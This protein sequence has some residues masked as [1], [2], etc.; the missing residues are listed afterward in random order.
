MSG[1]N[2]EVSV[3]VPAYNEAKNVTLLHRQLIQ[4]LT[5]VVSF[6]IIFVDDGSTDNTFAELK[7][8][9][10]I[11]IIRL[12][13]N[14]G[15]TAAFAAGIAVAQGEWVVTIDGDLENDPRDILRLLAKTKDG[16]DLVS[17][18]RQDRWRGQFFARQLP[19]WLANKLISRATAVYLHDHG[20]SLKIYRRVYLEN[21]HIHGD[22]HRMLAAY[23]VRNCGARIA[24]LPVTF[25]PRIYGQSKYGLSRTFKVILDIITFRF[26]Q[27]YGRQPMHFFGG[28]GLLS[29]FLALL[30]AGWSLGLRLFYGTHFIRT[31]LPI[32]VMMLILVGILFILLGLLAELIIR[33]LPNQADLY[34]VREVVENV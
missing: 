8:L 32:L 27:R 1:L 2:P 4:V 15:Q 28:A 21:L 34:R 25:R 30:T 26:F 7:K 20:C 17:G 24:E 22:L 9:S 31:P 16:F 29:L 13:R 14:F 10:P 19:S 3:I 5:G 12:D 11:R 33:T 18:W 23:I 6:E